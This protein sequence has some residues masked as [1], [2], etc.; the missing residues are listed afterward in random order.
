MLQSHNRK[1]APIVKFT[2]TGKPPLD[3]FY[4]F[5]GWKYRKFPITRKTNNNKLQLAARSL[6]LM[7]KVADWPPG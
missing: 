1:T 5:D 4:P 3:P 2:V 6:D 7:F